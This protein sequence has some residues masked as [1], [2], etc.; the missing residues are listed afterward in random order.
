MST[1]K[2]GTHNVQIGQ[3]YRDRDTR[4]KDRVLTVE[5]VDGDKAWVRANTTGRRTRVA[6]RRLESRDYELVKSLPAPGA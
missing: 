5:E 3:R 1:Q 4:T 2:N 6:C